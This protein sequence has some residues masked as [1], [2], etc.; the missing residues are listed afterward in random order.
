MAARRTGCPNL[1]PHVR[2]RAT[3]TK[4]LDLDIE[5]PVGHLGHKGGVRGAQSLIRVGHCVGH[6]SDRQGRD[7][8]SLWHLG[9]VPGRIKGDPIGVLAAPDDVGERTTHQC[10][11]H[12][13]CRPCRLDPAS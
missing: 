1:S 8:P 7:N 3:A 13:A 11:L 10:I 4:D 6:G 2:H 12:H 9:Q 5:R